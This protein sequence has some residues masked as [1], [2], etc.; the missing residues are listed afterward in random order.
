MPRTTKK[1]GEQEFI[2]L[3]REN[4]DTACQAW[5]PIYKLAEEDL[6]FTYDVGNGQWPES[7]KQSREE[8]HRPCLTI[9]KLQKFVRQ[10]RGNMRANRPRIKV[11]PVDSVADPQKAE[12][13]NGLI[14][15]IE[16]SSGADIAYDTA[17]GFAVASSLGYWRLVTEYDDDGTFNQVIKLKRIINPSSV[18]F[19]PFAKE[20]TMEDA[21]YCFVE[22]LMDEDI[23]YATYPDAEKVDWDNVTDAMSQWVDV[24]G[25]KVKICEY[26][27]KDPV[28]TEIADLE[29]VGMVEIGEETNYEKRVF[30]QS[31]IE[32]YKFKVKKSRKIITY[33]VKYCKLNGQGILEGPKDWPGKYIPIIPVFGDEVVIKGKRYLLSWIRGAKGPQEMYNY[34]A[35]SAAETVGQV[36]KVPNIIADEQIAGYEGEWDNA[37]I[38][39]RQY[40]RY[41]HVPGLP[42]PTQNT[43]VQI[44]AGIINQ[45]NISAMDIEDHLGQYEAAKGQSSNERT[46]RAIQMRIEQSDKGAFTFVD[47]MTRAI[48]YSGKQLIDLIP[49]IYDSARVV[50][51]LGEDGKTTPVEINKPKLIPGVGPAVVNDL[52]VGKFDLIATAGP[53]F[54]SKRQENMQ[55]MMDAL[56]YAPGFAEVIV[57]LM[58][59][60]SDSPGA[61]EVYEQIRAEVERQQQLAQS[62]AGPNGGKPASGNMPPQPS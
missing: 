37:N 3:V 49:K 60:Y 14:R 33:K 56:Q 28:V 29:N 50:Q 62:Q 35:T 59:K 2:D 31:D 57:P 7:V 18:H 46:G 5:E 32:F 47:N 15:Q 4:Y 54:D 8:N 44:P 23:Y 10:M 27:W 13:F 16:Y 24:A 12:I 19:D 42:A 9:N 48:V 20:F 22:D 51:M 41:H 53:S 17:Y 34:F 58:F 61:Q 39:P 38:V 36:P 40:L 6:E 55:F 1:Q 11:I 52:R 45:M 25:K 43:Q 26:F 30:S 21:M